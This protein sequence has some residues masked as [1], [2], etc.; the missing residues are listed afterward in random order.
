MPYASSLQGLLGVILPPQKDKEHAKLNAELAQHSSVH[1]V[2]GSPS[3]P[4][5]CVALFPPHP[6]FLSPGHLIAQTLVYQQRL[7]RI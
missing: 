3:N 2:L 1:S 5:S 6:P 4:H 7:S